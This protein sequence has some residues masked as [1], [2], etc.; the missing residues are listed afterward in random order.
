MVFVIVEQ[1]GAHSFRDWRVLGVYSTKHNALIKGF[2]DIV[3][4]G[5][6][7]WNLE[8]FEDQ[9]GEFANAVALP[10]IHIEEWDMDADQKC[11]K[12]YF[13]GYRDR[14]FRHFIDNHL[15]NIEQ[16]RKGSCEKQLLIWKEKL[17]QGFIPDELMEFVS[18]E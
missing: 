16:T 6:E 1:E 11:K 18:N 14:P 2:Q 5:L 8:H 13:L 4:K 9:A 15:K 17:D 12:V 3:K 10:E 7:P